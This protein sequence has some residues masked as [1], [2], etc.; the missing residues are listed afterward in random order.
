MELTCVWCPDHD[1]ERDVPVGP[2]CG[3]PATHLI[4]WHDG[5]RR[6][7]PACDDHLDIEPGAPDHLIVR[8]AQP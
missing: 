4:L 7:S 1:M 5:S 8:L 2:P 6:W 3:E